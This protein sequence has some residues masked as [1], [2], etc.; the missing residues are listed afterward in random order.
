MTYLKKLKSISSDISILY[1]EDDE[2]LRNSVEQYL[3]LIF[4]S[5][6][7]AS[8]GQEG[9]Q[10]FEKNSYDIIITDIQMPRM[11]GIEL[12]KRI[13]EQIPD[14]EI[15]I[16]TAFSEVPYLL[17]AIALGASSYLVKPIDFDLINQNLYKIVDKINKFRENERYKTSLEEMV[18]ARTKKNIALEKE[19]IENYEQTLL[20]L[21]E[22]VEHRDTYTGG[23]SQRVATYS[24]LIAEKMGYSASECDLIYRAGILHDIGKIETPDAV[25]LKPG[26]LD[27]IEHRLIREHVVTGA[28]MLKKIPMYVELS[29]II[30]SHHER[31][32]G[33][34]YPDGIAGDDIPPLSR[35]MIVADAFD[36]MTTNRIYKPRMSLAHAIEE[37]KHFSGIQFHSEVVDVAVTI[38]D[39]IHID[40]EIS[41]LPST[42]M[43]NKRFA[44]FF[45]DSVTKTYNPRY[46]DLILVQNQNTSKQ[47]YF[48]ALFIHD[49]TAYNN[50]F[51][52]D[53]GDQLLRSVANVLREC[54]SNKLIF[55][56]HGDDFIILS[57]QP[58]D[59]DLAVFNSLLADSG[60]LITLEYKN[61]NTD[62]SPIHSLED[63][64]HYLQ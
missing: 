28:S 30:A 9:L 35:I 49:F 62:H 59:H 52:W 41:Q 14:Q 26:K 5:I 61:I 6:D 21:V 8:D 57:E 23:H 10:L 12:I 18:E 25:L 44:F 39:N 20:S 60:H 1:V 58:F 22:L 55:R 51:G 42:E 54:Y 45:E 2:T 32:D 3:K 17:E 46:L 15:I 11:N 24:R 13:K 4:D 38:L 64:E 53:K 50:Q 19:K 48:I 36:A 7:C 63:L 34:G 31:Y 47:F 29:K 37:L 33:T 56:I 43:E 27:D 16:T 40:N